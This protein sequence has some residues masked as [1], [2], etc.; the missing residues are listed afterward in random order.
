MGI[1]LKVLQQ[2]NKRWER[3]NKNGKLLTIF[4]GG[5]WVFLFENFW[6]KKNS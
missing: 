6:N 5:W 2:K 3:E 4:E 1:A